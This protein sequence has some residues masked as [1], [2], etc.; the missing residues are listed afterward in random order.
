MLQKRLQGLGQGV[1]ELAADVIEVVAGETGLVRGCQAEGTGAVEGICHSC[2]Y[3]K[4]AA[5]LIEYV[6]IT[7]SMKS[8]V[9]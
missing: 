3:D 8:S 5:I 7:F 6:H 9:R 2:K 1:G 4:C